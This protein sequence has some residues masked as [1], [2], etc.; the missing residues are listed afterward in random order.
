MGLILHQFRKDFRQFGVLAVVWLVLL[1]LDLGASMGWVGKVGYDPVRGGF[2][3]PSGWIGS[4][5][6]CAWLVFL[7]LPSMVVLADSPARREGFLSTR[8]MPKRDLWLAKALFLVTVVILPAVLQ[9]LTHLLLAGLPARFVIHGTLER[10]LFV[11]PIPVIAALFSALWRSY[12][13]WAAGLGI[14]IGA[15]FGVMLL[16][17]LITFAVG[18]PEGVNGG[19]GL[20]T[21]RLLAALYAGAAAGFVIVLWQARNAWSSRGRWPCVISAIGLVFV[22][23]NFWP[24]N[25]FNLRPADPAAAADMIN[26]AGFSIPMS[27]LKI[28]EDGSRPRIGNPTYGVNVTPQLNLAMPGA[29]VQWV[30]RDAIA[31]KPSGEPIAPLHGLSPPALFQSYGI[32]RD[33]INT[34][35]SLL[36]PDA[37]VELQSQNWF[38]DS[39]AYLGKFEVSRADSSLNDQMAIRANIE[40]RVFRW[41]KV[42]DLPLLP[43]QAAAEAFGRW[44]VVAS[45]RMELPFSGV[46]LFLKYERISLA[47]AADPRVSASAFWPGEVELVLYHPGRNIA[48]IE[49][50]NSGQNIERAAH[51]AWSQTW[52][53]LNYSQ[54]DW[55]PLTAKELQQCHLLIFRKIWLGTV[56]RQWT[57]GGFVLSDMALPPNPNQG[58]S[59]GGIPGSQ[60]ERQIAALKIPG[61][62]ASRQEVAEYLVAFL[63]LIDSLDWSHRV[64][65]QVIYRLASLVPAHLDILLDGLPAMAHRSKTAVIEAITSGAEERQERDI[66]AALPREPDLAGILMARGWVA[67][68]KDTLYQLL[69]S[70]YSLPFEAR[71]AI[72]SFQDPKTYPLLIAGFEANPQPDDYEMLRTLPGIEPDLDRAVARIWNRER[73]VL[74]A[75]AYDFTRALGL[76][77]RIGEPDALVQGYR[78]LDEGDPNTSNS[79]V[80]DAF[81]QGVEM[82]GLYP[83]QQKNY[84][85][86]AVAWFRKHHPADFVFDPVRR[87]FVLKPGRDGAETA[88]LEP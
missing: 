84:D 80:L 3:S 59:S 20:D 31:T 74:D 86:A 58:N 65:A 75:N 21:S 79:W 68:A 43:G 54:T 33:D 78:L 35:S 37:F 66:I 1:L 2:D 87:R 45:K 73:R 55:K 48:R 11:L 71:Q 24:W 47:T 76:A 70:P 62:N 85:E 19:E 42:A 23:S 15:T 9:E 28:N 25:F 69:N 32:P 72:A 61:P 53:Q 30:A 81:R 83:E 8:P 7:L 52:I 63:R 38:S 14:G 56:P 44:T 39:S 67:D 22:I 64:S 49:T 88:R 5:S 57:S 10:L 41:D 50:M 46:S 34:W 77:L 40:A 60:F 27:G 12:S 16:L 4:Q 18:R 13:D 51:T 36:P 82:R 29:E 6:A 17:Q 26:G